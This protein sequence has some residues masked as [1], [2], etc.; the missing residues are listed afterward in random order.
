MMG[1]DSAAIRKLVQ[2]GQVISLSSVRGQFQIG[3]AEKSIAIETMMMGIMSPQ[4]SRLMLVKKITKLNEEVLLNA[5]TWLC[6]VYVLE[7]KMHNSQ[8]IPKMDHRLRQG[9]YMG[10]SPMHANC[11]W[12]A[13][14]H[15]IIQCT[16]MQMLSQRDGQT[17]LR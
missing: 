8:K 14:C 12:G 11:R 7:P 2:D 3:P 13:S 5:H 1:L 17:L 9:Q 16:W 4:Q 15:S 6:P 10:V